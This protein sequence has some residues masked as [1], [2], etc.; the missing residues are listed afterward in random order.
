MLNT[1]KLSDEARG[2]AENLIDLE[3]KCARLK[4]AH[5]DDWTQVGIAKILDQVLMCKLK[6]PR[7]Q[8]REQIDHLLR[9]IGEIQKEITAVEKI[10]KMGPCMNRCA[11]AHHT[12][13]GESFQKILEKLPRKVKRRD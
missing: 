6:F 11:H 5:P 8:S 1:A 3:D 7:G 13:L 10:L 2:V 4:N 9:E 12:R